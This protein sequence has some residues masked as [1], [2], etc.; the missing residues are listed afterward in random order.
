MQAVAV[1]HDVAAAHARRET[2]HH[3]P[4]DAAQLNAAYPADPAALTP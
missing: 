4:L 3:P 1:E 2:A